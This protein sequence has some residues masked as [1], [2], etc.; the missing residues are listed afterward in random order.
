MIQ[1]NKNSNLLDGGRKKKETKLGQYLLRVT[2]WVGVVSG[3]IVVAR[4]WVNVVSRGV[5]GGLRSRD[6]G[7][8]VRGW[9][10]PGITTDLIGLLLGRLVGDDLMRSVRAETPDEDGLDTN[11]DDQGD[12]EPR[13]RR[14]GEAPS[15]EEAEIGHDERNTNQDG[16]SGLLVVGTH[17]VHDHGDCQNDQGVEE[18]GVAER[19]RVGPREEERQVEEPILEPDHIVQISESWVL[20]AAVPHWHEDHSRSDGGIDPPREVVL[21]RDECHVHHYIENNGGSDNSLQTMSLREVP[22][23]G[24]GGPKEACWENPPPN[25]LSGR[26]PMP[27]EET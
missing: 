23:K 3:G 9:A 20:L 17:A 18:P 16:D 11:A 4:L 5:R 8:V 21:K 19:E 24:T 12:Q 25:R 10:G 13:T 2:K 14:G 7:G 26:G 15:D 1:S 27:N 6:L 22:V